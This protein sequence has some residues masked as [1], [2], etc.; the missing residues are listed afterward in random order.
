[1][2]RNTLLGVASAALLVACGGSDT[3]S[4]NGGGGATNSKE[5]ACMQGVYEFRTPGDGKF[6]FDAT[7]DGNGGVFYQ[8]TGGDTGTYSVSGDTVTW[9]ANGAGASW[10]SFTWAVNSRAADCT[11]LQ[12]G[13]GAANPA[14]YMTATKK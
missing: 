13:G 1:M 10:G 4:A 8:W 14:V 9:Q 12:V 7:F 5:L 11:I 2:L 6:H 3:G